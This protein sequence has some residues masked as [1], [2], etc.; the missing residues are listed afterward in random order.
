M[1]FTSNSH[2]ATEIILF[3]FGRNTKRLAMNVFINPNEESKI[4]DGIHS[5]GILTK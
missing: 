4:Y 5:F 2:K 3:W 1:E